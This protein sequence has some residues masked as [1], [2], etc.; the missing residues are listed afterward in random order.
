MLEIRLRGHD[1][2][3]RKKDARRQF[4]GIKIF[5]KLEW[6]SSTVA[7][8]RMIASSLKIPAYP[9]HQNAYIY[10]FI[11][12]IHIFI[13]CAYTVTYRYLLFLYDMYTY[14]IIMHI[15]NCEVQSKATGDW[16]GLGYFQVLRG[17]GNK[18]SF[19]RPCQGPDGPHASGWYGR[20]RA[21]N[22]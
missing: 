13:L 22:S 10:I 18:E 20:L 21:S 2:T 9:N 5:N 7:F 1:L 4:C 12:N 15:Y 14:V 8:S 11:I 6:R 3:K 16:L 17:P 19:W